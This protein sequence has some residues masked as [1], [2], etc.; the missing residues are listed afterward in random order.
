MRG[1]I[2][3]KSVS[4]KQHGYNWNVVTTMSLNGH[5]PTRIPNVI[6]ATRQVVSPITGNMGIISNGGNVQRH[7]TIPMPSP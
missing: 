5:R 6:V 4:P 7:T 3:A 1:R 2:T